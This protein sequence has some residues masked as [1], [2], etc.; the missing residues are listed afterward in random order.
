[1]LDYINNYW[2]AS[3][4]AASLDLS[5]GNAGSVTQTL[6]GLNIGQSY[7]IIFDMSGN[8]S[9]GD[10]EKTM[11]VSVDAAFEDFDYNTATEGTTRGDMQWATMSFVFTALDTSAD[12]TFASLETNAWGPALDNVSIGQVPIP[13]SLL[14]LLGGLGAIG[15]VRRKA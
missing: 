10:D 3:D 1:M 8:P 13:A 7:E 15:A 6:S 2:T 14:L 9:G 12:L 4:G 5:A 11:R